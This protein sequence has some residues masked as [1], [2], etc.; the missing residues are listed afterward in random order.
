[1]TSLRQ[2][3]GTRPEPIRFNEISQIAGTLRRYVAEVSIA[4]AINEVRLYTVRLARANGIVFYDVPGLNSGLGKHL[5]ESREML[6]DCD[7]V[8]CIQRSLTPSLEA[9]EQKLVEFVAQGDAAVGIAAKLFVFAGQIDLIPSESSLADR[10]GKLRKDWRARGKLPD[11]HI[12]DGSAAAYLLL[13]D[14]ASEETKKH[15]I[16]VDEMRRRL[17]GLRGLNGVS[18][19]QL[20][21]ATGIPAIKRRIEH[22][23]EEERIEV[24]RKRCEEPISLLI[25][26]ARQVYQQVRQRYPVDPDDAKRKLANDRRT[27]FAK[28]FGERWDEIEPAINRYY[29]KRFEA[30]HSRSI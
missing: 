20:I 15:L 25:D 9:H 30:G 19:E 2:I 24:L 28:W 1:M 11:D 23:L 7:A 4:H 16:G 8:I 14:T 26:T 5:D 22:Y 3:V 21:A 6:A 13:T 18:D 12:I 17:A 29:I 27:R 10:L